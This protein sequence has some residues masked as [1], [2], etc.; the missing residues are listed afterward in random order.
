M[1]NLT[2]QTAHSL[3]GGYAAVGVELRYGFD[4][5]QGYLNAVRRDIDSLE[6]DLQAQRKTLTPGFNENEWV[7]FRLGLN[8][9]D[10]F[11]IDPPV[12]GWVHF[13]N[14][15]THAR[16]VTDTD[17]VVA[18][19]ANFDNR[20]GQFYDA[21]KASGGTPT[22]DRRKTGPPPPSTKADFGG[23]LHDLTI[24]AGIALAGY[25]I[26]TFLPRR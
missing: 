18:E 11:S 9:S 20:F 25:V 4:D 26:V 22:L 21:F 12:F 10:A 23:M 19:I 5:E 24:F 3:F 6:S 13:L 16:E 14:N 15:L 1:H 17:R 7:T 8:N 2:P